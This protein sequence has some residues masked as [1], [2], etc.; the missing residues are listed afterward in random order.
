MKQ[1]A[2]AENPRPM[3]LGNH[4]PMPVLVIAD[5]EIVGD[6]YVVVSEDDPNWWRAMAVRN[7]G[8]VRL[9]GGRRIL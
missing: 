5:G 7:K 4:P 3:L 6:C 8:A 9:S 2:L 1:T